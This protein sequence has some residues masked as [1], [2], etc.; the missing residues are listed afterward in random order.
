MKLKQAVNTKPFL[1][2]MEHTAVRAGYLLTGDIE[3][4]AT[5]AKMPDPAA[6][7]IRPEDKIAELLRFAVSDESFELRTRLGTAIGS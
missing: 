5:L 4:C 7:P 2:G 3:L 6:I 1:E